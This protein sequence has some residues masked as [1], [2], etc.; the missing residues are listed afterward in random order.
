[1]LCPSAQPEMAGSVI[2]G[3]VGGTVDEPRVGYLTEVLPT[4]LERLAL[5]LPVKPTE[6]FRFGA[7][8][9]GTACRH[10]DGMQCR[11]AVRTVQRLEPVVE[12]LPPCPV[13]SDCRW[14]R[15]EGRAACVRCPQVVTEIY[16]PTERLQATAQATEWEGPRGDHPST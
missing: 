3:I 16:A 9:A 1:L 2:F 14:W 5:A 6:V 10:F 11:L 12:A 8:C 15:Q 7:P 13:R 4:T